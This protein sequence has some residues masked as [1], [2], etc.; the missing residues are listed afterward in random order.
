LT[1]I[2]TK[3]LN[4]SDAI[5]ASIEAQINQIIARRNEIAGKAIDMIEG[6]AFRSPIDARRR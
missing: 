6:A 4:G 2:S 5:Y 3:A 1:R